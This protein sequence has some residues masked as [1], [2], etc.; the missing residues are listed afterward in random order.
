MVFSQGVQADRFQ[1]PFF[2]FEFGRDIGGDLTIQTVGKLFY[3][4]ARKTVF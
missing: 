1:E 2:F 3:D 4:Q